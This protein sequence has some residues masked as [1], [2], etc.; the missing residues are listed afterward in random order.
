MSRRVRRNLAAYLMLLPTLVLL[1]VFTVYPIVNSFII[2]FYDWDMMSPV[3]RFVG[4]Q[5]YQHIL[6]DPLFRR[7]FGNTLLYVVC[8]VPSVLLLGLLA[9]VL[10]NAKIRFRAAFRTTLFLPYITSLAATGIVWSWIFNG[11]YGLLNFVL[12]WV[13][14]HGVDWLNNARYT[15]F[16]L[17]LFGVWQNVGYVAVIFLAGL[18]NIS[19]EYYESASVDG[20]SAWRKFRHITWP[21]L[22]PTSYFLL[23]LTTIEAFKVFLQ[24][25]VLYG[26][27]PG[28]NDSGLTLLYYMFNEGF[29]DFKMG[30][31]CAAAYVLFLIIFI[32]TLLQTTLSR[33]VNY[34]A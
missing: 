3:K 2:S 13:G 26:E 34:S 29:S 22:S 24:V 14:I 1:G 33:R 7:A 16:N 19:R 28:P 21:L 27:S 17:V 8:F 30:Y 18:Q 4:L 31:A 25:Y 10:L 23:L 20:A 5:N 6:A 32:F 9:A 12:S 11:Q 15:M